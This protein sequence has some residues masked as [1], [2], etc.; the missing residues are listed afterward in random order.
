MSFRPTGDRIFIKA[1]LPRERFG[2]IVLPPATADRLRKENGLTGIVRYM[3]PGCLMKTGERWPMP[4]VR[5]GDRVLYLDQPWPIVKIGDEELV[6]M[7]DDGLLA[8][9]EA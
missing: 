2:S 9:L 4:D 8:V 3:G 5:I 1:D 6:S 7:R